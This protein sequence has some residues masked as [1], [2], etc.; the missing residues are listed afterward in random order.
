M[1]SQFWRLGVWHQVVSGLWCFW[2][3]PCLFSISGG[4]LS[5]FG[6]PWLVNAPLQS[7]IFLGCSSC[8]S[9][10]HLPSVCVY[11][12]IS[13]FKIFLLKKF[14]YWHI[15]DLQ[16]CVNFC[17]TAMWFSYICIC[18]WIYMYVYTHTYIYIC[19]YTHY[20]HIHDPGLDPWFGTIPWW[21][22]RQPTPVFLPGESHGWRSLAGYRPRE[23]KES[24][25]TEP[26]TLSHF[27]RPHTP[28]PAKLL[29]MRKQAF[30]RVMNLASKG[31]EQTAG[32]KHSCA[33][34]ALVLMRV[35]PASAGEEMASCKGRNNPFP[36]TLNPG[37]NPEHPARFPGHFPFSIYMKQLPFAHEHPCSQKDHKMGFNSFS[38]GVQLSQ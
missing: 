9:L 3:L 23:C 16:Y 4:F 31:S 2:I 20:T 14:F 6:I 26:L 12:Q 13:P 28:W 11:G 8:V 34:S 5:I 38:A 7:C 25:T 22:E 15:V 24:E 18:N 19:I 33:D 27:Q 36:S 1:V 10:S 32:G 29:C 17:C 35:Q 30:K 37:S 21:K